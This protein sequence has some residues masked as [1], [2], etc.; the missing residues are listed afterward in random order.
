M[1]KIDV[2]VEKFLTE[3]QYTVIDGF[4]LYLMGSVRGLAGILFLF[5]WIVYRAFYVPA[6]IK[7]V[8]NG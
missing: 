7:K 8:R 3:K 4:F 2:L 6:I 1:K 5:G